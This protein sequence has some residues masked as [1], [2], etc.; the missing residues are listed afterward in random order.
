VATKFGM[1][2]VMMLKMKTLATAGSLMLWENN[3]K[4]SVGRLMSYYLEMILTQPT[5]PMENASGENF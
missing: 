1:I 3:M 2:L 4:V 5:L